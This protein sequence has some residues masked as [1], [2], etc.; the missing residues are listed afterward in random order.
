MPGFT[1]HSKAS[2]NVNKLLSDPNMHLSSHE[3]IECLLHCVEEGELRAREAAGRDGI[4]FIGNTGAG[5]STMTNFLH[6]CAMEQVTHEQ[7]GFTDQPRKKVFRVRPDSAVPEITAIGH[8]NKSMTF[9]P[10]VH[11]ADASFGSGFAFI[12]CPGFLD[13]RGF[14]INVANAINIRRTMAAASSARIVVL[15]N[16]HALKADKGKGVR[17]LI[18]ILSGL[19]GSTDIIQK[20][21]S[22]LVGITH[23]PIVD[24]DGD[25]YDL[26]RLKG[27][28]LDGSGM[29][30]AHASVLKALAD[31]AFVYHPLG[32][33]DSTWL[34]RAEL[35]QRIKDLRPLS[36][37]SSIF[38]TVLTPDDELKLRGV[39]KSLVGDV[40]KHVKDSH[41]GEAASTLAHLGRIDCIDNAVVPRLL[42]DAGNS[43]SSGLHAMAIN[44]QQEVS[45]QN[46]DS[47]QAKL[48]TLN[49]ALSAMDGVG[50]VLGR[51][52]DDLKPKA[53]K[54]PQWLVLLDDGPKPYEKAT[55][56]AIERAY[57]AGETSVKI[58]AAGD[59]Y[60]IDFQAMRQIRS[61]N[62][63]RRREIIRHVDGV[64]TTPH[65]PQGGSR[66][67]SR[68]DADGSPE[69]VSARADAEKA[70]VKVKYYGTIKSYHLSNHA[71]ATGIL[72]DNTINCS[73]RGSYGPFAYFA[74]TPEDCAHK[75]N[76]AHSLEEGVLLTAD[77]NVGYALLVDNDKPS[78]AA[79]RFLGIS[80]HWSELTAAKLGKA[81][82]RSVYVTCRNGDE[83]A[84][85]EPKEQ[86]KN[87][88]ISNYVKTNS[89]TAAMVHVPF[90]QWPSWVN[91][92]ASSIDVSDMD[93][94]S[95]SS[96]ADADRSVA[97]TMHGVRVNKAGRPINENGQ[98]M[99][100]AE[101]RRRGWGGGGRFRAVDI[102][103]TPPST[104]PA[105]RGS[106]STPANPWNAFQQAN[107]QK[108]WST[109]RMKAEYHARQARDAPRSAPASRSTGGGSSA[110][111]RSA[112]NSFNAFQAA[113]AGQGLS[114]AAMS[115]AY[116]NSSSTPAR[117]SPAAP[118]PRSAAPSP[119]SSVGGGSR[120]TN[121]WNAFQ[122][123]H[124]GQGYSRSQ[125]SSAYHA[126]TSGGG[127]S[128][129]HSSMSYG[130]GGGGGG[131]SSAGVYRSSGSANGAALHTG[132]RGGRYYYT[133]GGN[134]R[135]V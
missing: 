134:K 15:I 67:R 25:P 28:L 1:S 61:D 20:R 80:G 22:L 119:R 114:R 102:S 41:Y 77:V 45:E 133:S 56:E 19:F 97:Q 42:T 21:S 124:A 46:F 86:I 36:D 99:S 89:S 91:N 62:P 87:L 76:K 126:S 118:S 31:S 48:D 59:T 95:A 68:I 116:H 90:W 70:G 88:R 81:G 110:T 132:S 29:S 85:A 54:G 13:N 66:H 10:D 84:V 2:D 120:P 27:E 128:G 112:N 63:H 115:A 53:A 111:P 100:Y 96:G 55:G 50:G 30:D 57:Q 79:C 60:K 130:G 103:D 33:G 44:A 18:S 93:V 135:Y 108:G 12:D 107:S 106:S 82:C 17:D 40:E 43:V 113:H 6:G 52:L 32:K 7:L 65:T 9:M 14:E 16:Y 3:T 123:A 131:S 64:A 83:F 11:H 122:A 71:G 78:T 26:D 72:K 125:M 8:T 73:P 69:M 105:S 24:G 109:S 35:I 129:G 5:K 51:V 101:A 58:T 104:P 98:F 49:D 34:S 94:D 117:A 74:K 121:S 75:A 4:I 47:A 92:L 127:S 38:R 37:P 23:A 39:V